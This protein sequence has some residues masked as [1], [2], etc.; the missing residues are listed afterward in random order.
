MPRTDKVS[1]IVLKQPIVEDEK[2]PNTLRYVSSSLFLLV[3]WKSLVHYTISKCLFKTMWSIRLQFII[4]CSYL[5][6]KV[7]KN[8]GNCKLFKSSNYIPNKMIFTV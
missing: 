2:A 7:I 3:F 4:L 5:S 1:S 8:D 6:S